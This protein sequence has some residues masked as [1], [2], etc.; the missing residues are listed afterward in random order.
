MALQRCNLTQS[1]Y[2]RGKLCG[3]LLT[4]DKEGKLMA[5]QEQPLQTIDMR[6]F[7][8]NGYLSDAN[9]A[10]IFIH[11][12]GNLASPIG[13]GWINA[14]WTLYFINFLRSHGSLYK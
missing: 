2:I 14:K 10:R 7:T 4:G 1:C 5:S 6:C 13:R 9:L 8:L 12:N 3:S 11:L